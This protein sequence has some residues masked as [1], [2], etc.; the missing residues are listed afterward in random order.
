M[1]GLDS[2]QPNCFKCKHF[3]VTWDQ[4]FP[5]GCRAFQFKGRQLPSK[6]VERASGHP[7]L[8]FEGKSK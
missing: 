7:C 2:N 8:K 1:T 3:Y 6:A 4:Q 5:K